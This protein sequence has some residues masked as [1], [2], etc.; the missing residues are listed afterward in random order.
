MGFFTIFSDVELKN[1]L[2]AFLMEV[3]NNSHFSNDLTTKKALSRY[4]YQNTDGVVDIIK[5]LNLNPDDSVL[6]VLS[7][8]I[9]YGQKHDLWNGVKNE[10]PSM[11]MNFN[12]YWRDICE[13][14]NDSNWDH[15]ERGVLVMPNPKYGIPFEKSDYRKTS[16]NREY[17]KMLNSFCPVT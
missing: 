9:T 10:Y 16:S 5:T 13:L 8:M 2:E 11:Y 15:Y 17:L 3:A 6:C 4:V 7:S 1:E 12:S 14:K